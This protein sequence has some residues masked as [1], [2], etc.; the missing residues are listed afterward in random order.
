[1]PDI[2]NPW[3]AEHYLSMA[4]ALLSQSV[5]RPVPVRAVQFVA[6]PQAA[7]AAYRR[8]FN[9]DPRFGAGTNALG[10]ETATLA[11]PL[12]THDAY[13]RAIL[14]RVADS[15]RP[16]VAES[17]LDLARRKIARALVKGEQLSIKAIA[18]ACGL[19][20]AALRARL[21]RDNTTFR[22]LMDA[23]R[24]DLAREHMARDMSATE[25]AYLLG[26]SEP[27]A[28]QHACRRWFGCSAGDMRR[29]LAAGED[30]K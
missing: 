3:I 16:P 14:E 24:R 6:A 28:F 17:S 2:D 15:Q 22:E 8:R 27:A 10:F 19:G 29:K 5:G 7:A 23:I 13:L 4:T 18:A 30:R 1:V 21:A 25:I 9:V 20:T 11:W 26:F 12:Q